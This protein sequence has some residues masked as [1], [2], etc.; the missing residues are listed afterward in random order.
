MSGDYR[1]QIPRPDRRFRGSALRTHVSLRVPRL[2]QLPAHLYQR[3][4]PSHEDEHILR[5]CEVSLRDPERVLPCDWR[6]GGSSSTT[7]E[8]QR[9]LAKGTLCSIRRGRS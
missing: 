4:G 8:V 1:G 2:R 5:A 6:N 3:L 9:S 7:I